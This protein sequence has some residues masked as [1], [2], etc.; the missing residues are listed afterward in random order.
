MARL[1]IVDDDKDTVS[2][3]SELMEM[4]GHEILGIGYDGKDAYDLYKKLKP[5][6]V[7]IDLL[8]SRY[9]GYYGIKMIK[10]EFPDAKIIVIS[11]FVRSRIKETSTT[12]F[13]LKPYNVSRL[14]AAIASML[15]VEHQICKV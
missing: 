5:D 8:M 9:D 6:I 13:L 1:I 2:T 4:N 3:L 7:L 12:R 11:G 10:K 14:R 15:P